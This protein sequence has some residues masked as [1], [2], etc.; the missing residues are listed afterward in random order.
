MDSDKTAKN[1]RYSNA[2]IPV[3][4][5]VMAALL[6]TLKLALSFIPNV[7]V[8]TLLILVYASVFGVRYAMPATLIFCAVEV[9]IYGIS[10]WVLLYFIYWPLLALL[11]SLLLK[12]KN[13]I[14]AII[15]AAVMGILFG[16]LSACADTLIAV[17][18]LTSAELSEYW[19]AYYLRGFFSFD[20][21]HTV[22]NIFIVGFLYL[23]LVKVCDALKLKQNLS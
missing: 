20:I 9:A 17:A 8:V 22:C 23:P 19:V 13:L 16:V 14:A 1:K 7:E 18:G 21:P 15:L 2:L 5:A 3:R 6:T 12:N 10:S 11:G 4:I